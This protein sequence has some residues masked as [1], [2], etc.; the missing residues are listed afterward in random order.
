MEMNIS[1][2]ST[3]AGSLCHGSSGHAR[4]RARASAPVILSIGLA[5]AYGATPSRAQLPDASAPEPAVVADEFHRGFQSMAWD[6]LV[7]RIH[8]EALAHLRIAV[9]ILAQVDTSGYVFETLLGGID[10]EAYPAAADAEVAIRIL[11]GVQREA[12]GLL[13]SLV[14]RRSEVIGVVE[15]GEDRHAV[16]RV[17]ALVQGAEPRIAVMT[18]RAHQGRWRVVDAEDLRVLHTAIRGLPIR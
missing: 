2:P 13:S 8:P 10:P 17:V 9:D 18:L 4:P 16:Y 11:G 12:P 14:T 6:G 3:P 1:L 7:Q 5:M 15:D